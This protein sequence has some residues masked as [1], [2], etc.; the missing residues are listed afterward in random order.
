M[1]CGLVVEPRAGLV[2]MHPDV[3]LR[4]RWQRREP[5]PRI[6]ASS[7]KP[8]WVGLAIAGLGFLTALAS[9]AA[10]RR[11]DASVRRVGRSRGHLWAP[12]ALLPPAIMPPDTHGAAHIFSMNHCRP[13]ETCRESPASS[14]H[15][16]IFGRC[17]T[18]G[19]R[20]LRKGGGVCRRTSWNGWRGKGSTVTS[21][22]IRPAHSMRNSNHFVPIAFRI[23]RAVACFASMPTRPAFALE[24]VSGRQ[25]RMQAIDF[26]HCICE[27]VATIDRQ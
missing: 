19:A 9:R 20:A 21:G 13:H 17:S 14:V 23:S 18:S 24:A 1:H 8:D 4:A 11:T 6:S 16:L 25:C 3:P 7:K 27:P 12:G 10:P 5:W 15:H 2:P 22:T 26:A